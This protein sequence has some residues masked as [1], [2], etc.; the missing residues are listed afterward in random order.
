MARSSR[1]LWTPLCSPRQVRWV[2]QAGPL[3][4]CTSERD[5]RLARGLPAQTGPALCGLSRGP[6]GGG[7]LGVP[8]ATE[9]SGRSVHFSYV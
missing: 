9:M 3:R 7:G 5:C 8:G 1:R 4:T 2:R 6:P